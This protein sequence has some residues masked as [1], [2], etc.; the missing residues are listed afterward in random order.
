MKSGVLKQIILITDGQSNIGGDPVI[1]AKNAYNKNIIVNTIG[2]VNNEDSNDKALDEIVS[3]A[4]A[5]GGQYEYTQINNLYQTMKSVTIKTINQT[6]QQAVNKQLKEIMGQGLEN[7]EPASRN[8]LLKYIEEYSAE[9]E[10]SCCILMDCSGSMNKKIDEARYSIMD[11]LDSFNYRK[12]K[13]NLAVIAFPG[14]KLENF[15]VIHS[16]SDDICKLKTSI[17]GT[18]A[19]G[20]TPTAP[21]IEKAIS[22]IE[23]YSSESIIFEEEHMGLEKCYG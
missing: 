6:I 1:S 17:Y 20:G 13:V 18:R 22:L 11:L 14:S 4:K 21:A 10:I 8:K 2:I 16:F 5:G 19:S 9:I 12:G 3:I 7:I 23:E 15:E